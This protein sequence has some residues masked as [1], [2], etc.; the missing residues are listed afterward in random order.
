[1]FRIFR[2][3]RKIAKVAHVGIEVGTLDGVGG[4]ENDND[5]ENNNQKGLLCVD[6]VVI[7]LIYHGEGTLVNLVA[8]QL[9][10]V[11]QIDEREYRRADDCKGG[12]EAEVLQQVGL[13]EDKSHEG[14]DGGD[15][16]QQHRHC[17]VAD[18]LLGIA[19]VFVVNDDMQH[20]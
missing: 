4:N 8:L 20:V 12:E 1:M 2:V 6:G 19:G 15:T 14:T 18:N 7:E 3:R 9:H 16:S 11:R 17:L 5:N 10:E 13:D